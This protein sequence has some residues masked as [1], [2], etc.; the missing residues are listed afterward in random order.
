MSRAHLQFE[1][2]P[3][4]RELPKTHLPEGDIIGSPSSNPSIFRVGLARS[5]PIAGLSP[6]L[7]MAGNRD[8][9]EPAR[10]LFHWLGAVTCW[11]MRVFT[12][13]GR[14]ALRWAAWARRAVEITSRA[15]R[16][17]ILSSARQRGARGPAPSQR[18]KFQE[19]RERATP[20]FVVSVA[21]ARTMRARHSSRF[22]GHVCANA[23]GAGDSIL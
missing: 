7:N 17:R 14:R 23:D 12:A 20:G 15:G 16:V 1:P 6:G 19:P 13:G 22:R 11:R 18:P 9:S 21:S 3:R 10:S 5:N 4:G 2:V 8:P